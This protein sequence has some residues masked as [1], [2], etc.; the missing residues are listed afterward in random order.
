MAFVIGII[1]G[2]TEK[3]RKVDL[4]MKKLTVCIPVFNRQSAFRH[5][6]QAAC[7]ACIQYSDDVEIVVS[8]NHSEEDIPSVFS[9]FSNLYPFLSMKFHRHPSNLGFA[10]NYLQVMSMA[11]GRF[12]WVIGS[13]DFIYSDGVGYLLKI[14]DDNS[15]VDF[16]CCNYDLAEVKKWQPEYADRKNCESISTPILKRKAP[17]ESKRFERLEELIRPETSNVYLGALTTGI[18]RKSR[19]DQ[20]DKADLKL[21]G[22]LGF[23]SIYTHCAI[24]ARGFLDRKA[25]YCGVSI[26]IVGEGTRE[27]STET[28][29]TLW[30]SSVPIIYFNVLGDM[31]DEYYKNGLSK[32]NY[33]ACLEDNAH[34]VGEHFRALV[35]M[36]LF[37]GGDMDNGELIKPV[38][39]F[40]KYGRFRAFYSGAF[41]VLQ[42]ARRMFGGSRR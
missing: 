38:K 40:L 30:R 20:T 16:I 11:S 2:N 17:K 24:Y 7:E 34:R 5:C 1:Q 28:G 12:S 8:D 32:E 13:D 3:K 25:Y 21:D 42:K 31:L 41:P 4:E 37:R 14:I 19:W 29:K 10:R 36:K 27:W 18:C 6:L 39:I 22:F 9:F 15:D 35:R 23:E 33:L 26:V